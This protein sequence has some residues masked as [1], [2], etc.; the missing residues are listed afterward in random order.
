[1]AIFNSYVSHYQRLT[2]TWEA[3]PMT[4]SKP[5][6]LRCHDLAEV[7]IAGILKNVSNDSANQKLLAQRG[8]VH[9]HEV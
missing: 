3:N 7:Y 1:M 4:P 9:C 6:K 8:A 2:G 5:M